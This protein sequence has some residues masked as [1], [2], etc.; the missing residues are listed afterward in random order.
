M[1]YGLINFF[2]WRPHIEHFN[3]IEK[4]LTDAG[5]EVFYLACNSDLENCYQKELKKDKYFD[6]TCAKCIAG[7]IKS[8]TSKSYKTIG[9]YK[10]RQSKENIR[11]EF[12][13]FCESSASTLLRCEADEDFVSM[14]FIETKSRLAISAEITFEATKQWILDQNLDAVCIF[15][16]RVDILRASF[17]ACKEL[18]K[19]AI[20]IERS[21]FGD[22]LQILPNE[23]CNGIKNYDKLIQKW[24]E[25]P[26]TYSQALLALRPLAERFLKKNYKEWRAYNINSKEYKWPKASTQ[27]IL[28][29]PSSKCEVWGHPDYVNN[30]KNSIAAYESILNKFQ[31]NLDN[32]IMRCHPVWA[33]TISGI[34]GESAS[35]FYEQWGESIGIKIIRSNEDIDTTSLIRQADLIITSGTT[36]TFEA[37]IFGKK[38]ILVMPS[39]FMNGKFVDY[40]SGEQ[41]LSKLQINNILIKLSANEQIRIKRY[42]IR[43][44]YSLSNR[45]TQYSKNIRAINSM[46]YSYNFELNPENILSQLNNG[47]L[48][49][50]DKGY[51]SNLDGENQVL[52]YIERENWSKIIQEC[53]QLEKVNNFKFQRRLPYRAVDFIRDISKPGD[54]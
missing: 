7:G 52:E 50:D 29:L 53:K 2:P 16:A 12:I 4:I 6:F 27:K 25:K 36:A 47:E 38:I 46:T 22:G 33:Q 34:D 42:A 3:F 5:H 9:D 49:E 35:K 54:V 51:A 14:K 23:N 48:I 18:K 43:A 24:S 1:K 39:A 30:W 37:G 31:I 32:V 13:N 21:W 8:Y 41:D 45:V 19:N 11:K 26:L 40:L 28:I 20:S 10:I 15:N 17:E 44:L